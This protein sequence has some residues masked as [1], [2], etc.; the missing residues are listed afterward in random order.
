MTDVFEAQRRQAAERGRMAMLR[1]WLD[2]ILGFFRTAPGEHLA[3]VRQDLVYVLRSLRRAP[4]FTAT[5]IA[6]L[7][8]GIGGNMAVFSLVEAVLL[9]PLPVR[10]PSRL[11]SIHV[12]DHQTPGYTPIS[13]DNFRD[14]EVQQTVFESVAAIAFTGV[15]LTAEGTDPQELFAA[16]VTGRYFEVLG[17]HAAHGRTL[18][19]T[20][21]DGPAAG[22][23]A[24]LGHSLWVRAFGADPAV[25]G[26]TI[27]LNGHPF[28]VVGVMPA[29]FRG[30]QVTFETDL[31]LPLPMY[32]VVSPGTPW[33]TG[34]R[35]RWLNVIGRLEPG[36]SIEQA[37]TAIA[38]LG[39]RLADAYPDVNAGRTL[40]VRPLLQTAV[41][42]N[43]YGTVATAGVMLLAVAGV[44][45]LIA[46]V[47]LA[48][49]LL[50]RAAGRAREVARRA[51]LGASRA[52]IVRALLTE[53]VVLGLA[54]G[55]VGLAVAWG[56]QRWLWSARPNNFAQPAIELSIGGEVLVFGLVTAV[57][58][59]V[60][61]GLVPAL[62]VSRTDVIGTLQ[63]AGRQ[64]SAT[65][66]AR[67][68]GALVVGEVALSVV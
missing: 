31:Y 62:Q 34:R 30:T 28:T 66:S 44:V 27:G 45:L 32:D 7:A 63:Q 43:Q 49:L 60:I 47:N 15:R 36:V 54:G 57:V 59:G 37:H 41:D 33:F 24:V 25:I 61:F 64:T 17:V 53:S 8:I 68:R 55:T 18:G 67:L 5:A 12:V 26:R 10:E 11:G 9:N 16:T 50:A 1:L 3:G 38:H 52:R 40:A 46:C 6:A 20:D 4:A 51:A 35:W 65:G 48:N 13:V 23:V 22:P 58:A 14:I 39:D 42:P 29:S 2:T 19:L 21:D 56:L